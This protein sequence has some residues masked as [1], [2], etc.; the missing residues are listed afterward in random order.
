MNP[1]TDRWTARAL[2]SCTALAFA[3]N[4]PSPAKAQSTEA[5][6][7]ETQ[8][9][10]ITGSRIV[11]RD[12]TSATP[13][14]TVTSDTLQSSS[15]L[16]IDQG[17]KEM[18]Q[19]TGGVGATGRGGAGLTGLAGSDVQA[20]PTNSPGIA[21]L[22]LRGIGANRTLVLLDGRRTQP[23]NATLV[24][25]INTIP[26]A[27]LD[28]VEVITGG[29]GAT[30]G[31]DAVAG[32]VNFKLKRDY[33]G[34]TIDTSMGISERGD[35]RQF[36]ISALVGGN[37]ADGRGNA[38]LGVTYQDRDIIYQADRPFYQAGYTDPASSGGAV[39]F[40][41][42]FGVTPR[43][44]TTGVPGVVAGF[45]FGT[46]AGNPSQ[47]AVNQVFARYGFAPGEVT[48]AGPGLSTSFFFNKTANPLDATIFSG[49]VGRV[50]GAPAPNYNG[51]DPNVKILENGNAS[52]VSKEGYLQLPLRRISF[53]GS[54]HYDIT[55]DITAYV[56]AKF[57]QNNVQ[58]QST[59][60]TA[61]SQ[62]NAGITFDAATCGAA[63]GHPVPQ[64]LCDILRS[65]SRPNAPWSL[66]QS[67]TFM[68]PSRTE[69]NTYN[70]EVIGGFR[71]NVGIRDWTFDVFGGHGK[72]SQVTRYENF[73]DLDAYQTLIG[74][75]N[76]GAGTT[77]LHPSLGMSASCTSGLNP[78]TTA[79]VSQDCQ[80]LIQ[81]NIK[82]E[83]VVGQTQAEV[84]FQGG[85]FDLPAGEVRFA[86]GASYR[87]N[88]F[89][90]E[91]SGPLNAQTINSGVIS[92]PGVSRTEGKIFVKDFYGEVLIPLLSDLPFIQ[93]LNLNAGYRHSS[94]NT[95]G[96]VGTWK[97]TG[98]WDVNDWLKFRGGYQVANRAPNIAEIFQPGIYTVVNWPGGDPCATHANNSAYPGYGNRAD[99]PD[100]AQVL[101]LCSAISGGF[102]IGPDFVGNQPQLFP[103]GR[104]VTLGNP[105]LKSEEARTFTAGMVIRSPWRDSPWLSR[106]TLS[107]DYYNI[108]I[109]GAVSTLSTDYV[110]RQCFNFDGTSNPTYD[111]GN[112]FCTR[113]IREP[114]SGFWS[115]TRAF[116]ENLGKIH[117]AGID[118]NLN[119]TVPAPGLFGDEGSFT[120]N[121]AFNY[122]A[123]F[124]V[125]SLPGGPTADYRDTIGSNQYSAQFKWKL[126]TNVAYN[127]GPG[128]ISLTWRHLPKVRY[129]TYATS[130]TATEL[131][132]P[133]YDI[134]D[135]SGRI[136]ATSTVELRFGVDN[137][138]DKQPPRLGVR[139][140][141]LAQ[142]GSSQSGV[143]DPSTYDVLGRRFFLGAR[144]RF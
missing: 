98:D 117:T 58:T 82:A 144:L 41:S 8:A 68:G 132:I 118:A 21:T 102:P 35:G 105:D 46:P 50:T 61:F 127:F 15:D 79:P 119:W 123:K 96:S 1:R 44:N 140:G 78:F 16:S 134:F 17:L 53:F 130:T 111:P 115:A 36:E 18:P 42:S 66:N 88:N 49:V 45:D 80:D 52:F 55:D 106:L 2:M 112:E 4:A 97:V 124:D 33:S 34:V 122:L 77:F 6:A 142:G 76:Y 48:I 54:A 40:G 20:T 143:T 104:D 72:S 110:Y 91:P 73:I 74:L 67:M 60:A 141:T 39:F 51:T 136:A 113:I 38:M 114:Q 101:A 92:L 99:N 23:A 32:V 14:T 59:Y 25:D 125:Q 10:V 11:R 109:A 94:Y 62:L 133:A 84:N 108:K 19:F 5:D 103:L 83:T 135:L 9:I 120:T 63:V 31:A 138:F 24:V 26:K 37:F 107:V 75:P 95:A 100:R 22:D 81:A 56:Q 12:Y 93:A 28:S 7:Q 30:Y 65:R 29:A 47:A 128:A 139:A 57:D 121:I 86:A 129:F 3:F 85:L 90:Y 71:G 131:P 116:F 126:S 87:E 64:D 13:L 70:Y 69:T 89:F 43:T 27:A 137:L